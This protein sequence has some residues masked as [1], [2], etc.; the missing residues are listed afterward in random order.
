MEAR[1]LSPWVGTIT[2][3][4]LN[5]KYLPQTNGHPLFIFHVVFCSNHFSD[6]CRKSG[7]TDGQA[8][9]HLVYH[10]LLP[11]DHY[12]HYPVPAA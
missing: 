11:S 5:V 12:Y 7:T 9:P 10:R 8:I 4:I 2:W 1:E 3:D 6:Y